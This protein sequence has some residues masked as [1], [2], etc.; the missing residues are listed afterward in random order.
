M[1]YQCGLESCSTWVLSWLL[2]R[3][4]ARGMCCPCGRS[5][6]LPQKIKSTEI[7][8]L[9]VFFLLVGRTLSDWWCSVS[10]TVS[11]SRI[12]F[13]PFIPLIRRLLHKH[14]LSY[15]NLAQADI[16]W[17]CNHGGQMY[18]AT[19]ANDPTWVYNPSTVV[20]ST[21]PS[22]F[23]RYVQSVRGQRGGR[24]GWY[25]GTLLGI[26]MDSTRFISHLRPCLLSIWF[27]KFVSP[28]IQWLRWVIY[29]IFD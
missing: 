14:Y 12:P 21:L 15:P 5:K 4:F 8:L 24:W 11:L 7:F 19:L 1:Y 3:L 25:A 27:S 6:V 29:A 16:L 9:S 28:T 18:N 20:A 23:C 17:E 10:I 22:G 13:S 2:F 26:V